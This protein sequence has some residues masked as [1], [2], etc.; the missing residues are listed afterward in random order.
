MW[1]NNFLVLILHPSKLVNEAEHW[2]WNGMPWK[3][4]AV[5]SYYILVNLS[6]QS[7]RMGAPSRREVGHGMLAE[8]ALEPILPSEGDFPYTI[9]VESTITE[10]N[11]SSSMASICG[12]CLALLDAGVPVKRSVARIAMGT[13]LDTKE[14]GGDGAPL[15]L[16]D[17]SG[18]EDAS[19]DMDL[20]I[21]GDENGI[22]AFQMDIKIGGITLLVMQ[23][24]L[25]QAR[26]GKR[27]VLRTY[28]FSHCITASVC[29][30]NQVKCPSAHHHHRRSSL[31]MLRLSTS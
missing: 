5:H 20:K 16:S 13:V 21:Y 28:L 29:N 10:S 1:S 3:H 24:A 12:G 26:D 27:H 14:F 7:R 9:H 25:L 6:F 4:F 2:R 30:L 15:I 23:Q 8:R 19:G 18:S 11:G 17:I 22:T 31:C